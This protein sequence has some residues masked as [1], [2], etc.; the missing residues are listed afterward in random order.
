MALDP[1]AEM[2][3][4]LE[5]DLAYPKHLHKAH[6]NFPLAPETLSISFEQLSPYAKQCFKK[7]ENHK[8]YTSEKLTATFLKRKKYIVSLKNL[9]L[10]VKLGMKLLK[11]RKV[12]QFRQKKWLKPYIDL[13]TCKRASCST[14]FEANQFKLANNAVYGKTIQNARNYSKVCIARDKATARR[15]F[16]SPFYKS[17]TIVKEDLVIFHM[18]TSEVKFNKPYAVGFTILENAKYFMYDFWYNVLTK[19]F[20]YENLELLMSDTD[21][22][23]FKLHCKKG[24][25]HAMSKIAHHFDFSNYEKTNR[26]FSEENKMQLGFFKDEFK[27]EKIPVEFCGLRSKCYAIRTNNDEEKLTCK[28]V[29]RLAIKN[30]LAFEQYKS[31]LFHDQIVRESFHAIQTKNHKIKTVRV[32]KKALSNFDSKRYILSCKI[33]SRAYSYKKMKKCQ[34]CTHCETENHNVKKN[35]Q[36]NGMHISYL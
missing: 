28:G 27:G 16:S 35:A 21:S 17:H 30:R 22:F 25:H 12:L 11:I 34:K 36:K 13:C 1:E 31:T 8:N 2:S 29:G 10:Y 32:T 26:Y 20:G 5:V 3:C 18:E 7:I 14:N 6:E 24:Y 19:T 15:L 23:L 33:H 4:I 9:Q